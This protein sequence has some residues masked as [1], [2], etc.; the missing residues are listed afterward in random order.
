[1]VERDR[2]VGT[3]ISAVVLALASLAV[4]GMGG[5]GAGGASAPGARTSCP[6]SALPGGPLEVEAVVAALRREM[7]SL[8]RGL[9]DMGEPV[10]I[11]V[12]TYEIEGV[13]RLPFAP[14]RAFAQALRNRA[15]ELC[16]ARIVD[17]SWAVSLSLTRVQLPASPRI[18]FLAKTSKGWAA[19]YHS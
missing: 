7:P 12:R 17:R 2:R 15:L 18:V 5:G 8:Y 6:T 3:A 19:W 13:I 16:P 10:P 14:R 1:V 11:N 4:V 9:T